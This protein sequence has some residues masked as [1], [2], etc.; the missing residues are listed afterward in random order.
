[1]R[2]SL[3]LVIASVLLPGLLAAC[4][5]SIAT[6]PAPQAA[7]AP[8]VAIASPAASG[9]ATCN[10]DTLPG[11]PA[12]GQVSTSGIIPVLASSQK[13]VGKSRLVF[14]LIDQSNQPV[15]SPDVHLQMAFYDLCANPTAPAET[16]T[17]TSFWNRVTEPPPS[18]RR[19]CARCGAHACRGVGGL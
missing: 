19:A 11:W 13:V 8:V 12:A 6:S 5:G 10:T 3:R 2:V 17:P 4:A 16:L 7:D 18:S 9:D 1:V 15:A 14:S